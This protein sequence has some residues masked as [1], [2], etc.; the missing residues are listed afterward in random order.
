MITMIMMMKVMMH[1]DLQWL[2]VAD[3]VTDK[4]GV[5]IIQMM[6]DGQCDILI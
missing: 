4:L 6:H 2:D 3:R 1:E 5:I